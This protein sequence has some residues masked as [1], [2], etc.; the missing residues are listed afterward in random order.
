MTEFSYDD[1]AEKKEVTTTT[2]SGS[3]S[4]WDDKQ[5]TKKALDPFEMRPESEVPKTFAISGWFKDDNH[6]AGK[7]VQK[8]VGALSDKGYTLRMAAQEVASVIGKAA[9]S[10]NPPMIIYLPW[11]KF[12]PKEVQIKEEYISDVTPSE[13]AYEYAAYFIENFNELSNGIKT[14]NA[15]VVQAMLGDDLK[16]PVSMV[17]L[18][19]WG[20]ETELKD[21]NDKTNRTS[22]LMIKIAEAVNIPVYNLNDKNSRESLA[23]FINS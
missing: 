20:R 6:T 21:I 1:V 10:A 11:K 17:I 5:Y 12:E 15:A 3:S 14:F 13:E 19:T 4:S 2:S 8:T 18:H 16:S 23:N 9:A 7:M 22:V